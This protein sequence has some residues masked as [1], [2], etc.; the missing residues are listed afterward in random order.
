[1]LVRCLKV[2][3]VSKIPLLAPTSLDDDPQEI[4]PLTPKC[5]PSSICWAKTLTIASQD[6]QDSQ[7]HHQPWPQTAVPPSRILHPAHNNCR[8]PMQMVHPSSR[9]RTTKD[10]NRLTIKALTQSKTVM[11]M[12]R[13]ITGSRRPNDMTAAVD[14][15]S[16]RGST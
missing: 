1:M 15:K 6:S 13:C 10:E 9:P 7:E 12:S 16:A 3:G 11:E 2:A 4:L 8:K 14:V 5:K